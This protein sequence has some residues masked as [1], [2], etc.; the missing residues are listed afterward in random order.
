MDQ[1]HLIIWERRDSR[2]KS[3]GPKA[4][5]GSRVVPAA[6]QTLEPESE[7]FKSMQNNEHLGNLCVVPL[8]QFPHNNNKYKI[9]IY[10]IISSLQLWNCLQ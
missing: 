5:Q 6:T 2:I 8:S 9:M 1:Q 10:E 4:S 7:K 3:N